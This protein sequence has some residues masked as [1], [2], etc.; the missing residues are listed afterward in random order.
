ML[1]SSYWV[2]FLITSIAGGALS[3][4]VGFVAVFLF[5]RAMKQMFGEQQRTTSAAEAAASRA[6][7]AADA[8]RQAAQHATSAN[9]QA[10]SAN[11]QAR[12]AGDNSRQANE[13]LVWLAEQ[14]ASRDA[15]VDDLKE[16][17]D[18]LLGTRARQ[19]AAERTGQPAGLLV[20]RAAGD[21]D[22]PATVTGKHRFHTPETARLRTIEGDPA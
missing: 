9:E 16:R 12:T 5:R 1:S 2:Q 18:R 13:S 6:G 7:E 10:T 11:E 17:I 14:L 20:P 19:L 8:S 3:A 21:D 4:I 22:D 15:A